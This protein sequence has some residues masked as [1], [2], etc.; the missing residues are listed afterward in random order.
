VF[1][2]ALDASEL[3]MMIAAGERLDAL[4]PLDGLPLKLRTSTLTRG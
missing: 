1:E 4:D 2:A 3:R